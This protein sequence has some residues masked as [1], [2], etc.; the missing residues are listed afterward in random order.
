M[1]SDYYIQKV[2]HIYLD[3]EYLRFIVGTEK[4]YYMDIYDEDEEYYE[5]KINEYMI[6]CSPPKIESIII[7]DNKFNK[8]TYETK[9]KYIVENFMKDCG[10]KFSDIIKIIKIEERYER[11]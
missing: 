5:T 3:D 9:Y 6:N 11:N 2:L 10:K 8:S 7:Y 1:N 4:G